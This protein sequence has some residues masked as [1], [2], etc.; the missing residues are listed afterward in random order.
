MRESVFVLLI[1]D[2][3]GYNIRTF[4]SRELAQQ[5]VF[6][7]MRAH[8]D[9]FERK[10]RKTELSLESQNTITS[11]RKDLE[12]ADFASACLTWSA[13]MDETFGIEEHVVAGSAEE[14][15]HKAT[16]LSATQTALLLLRETIEEKQLSGQF[17]RELLMMVDAMLGRA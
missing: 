13:H 4:R 6:G 11:F 7:E 9:A 12:R 8:M 1:V 2:S 3:D 10:V 17:P 5:N 15:N 16:L 14:A